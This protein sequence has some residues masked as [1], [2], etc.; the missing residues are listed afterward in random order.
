MAERVSWITHKGT[1]ILRIDYSGLKGEEILP[2]VAQVS[3]VY[4]TQATGSVICL[5]DV[6]NAIATQESMDALKGLVRTTR[7]YDKRVAV[8][9]ISG[10]KKAFLAL[11]NLF[12]KHAMQ[13]FD[14]EQAALD[15]L[16]SA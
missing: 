4:R 6:R 10:V 3:A 1:R 9:G 14:D 11:I 16:V 2:V 13:A 5:I 12:A 15:W 7:D 8:L